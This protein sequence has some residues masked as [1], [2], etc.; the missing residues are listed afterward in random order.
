[1]EMY[2]IDATGNAIRTL[3]VVRQ[4]NTVQAIVGKDGS[5]LLDNKC[6]CLQPRGGRTGL[7]V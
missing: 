1:M 3:I 2:G 6:G 4:P 5:D 7:T